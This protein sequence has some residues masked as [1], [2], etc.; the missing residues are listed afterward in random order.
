[1]E[2]LNKLS[3]KFS[4]KSLLYLII[5][6][7]LS[8]FLTYYLLNLSLQLSG[9]IINP[10][11]SQLS[12]SGEFLKNQYLYMIN[13]GNIRFYI[14]AQCIDYA[15]MI[16]YGILLISISILLSKKFEDNI[17]WKKL[18]QYFAFFS[19]IAPIADAFENLLIITLYSPLTFPNWL[20]ILHSIFALIKWSLLII[21]IMGL[22]ISAIFKLLIKYKI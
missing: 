8:T 5:I 9:D 12:F 6:S 11:M 3:N 13:Y 2:F 17:K 14:I 19:I 18:C 22:L 1:M 10:I 20:A 4:N 21:V 15:F 16:S 7:I